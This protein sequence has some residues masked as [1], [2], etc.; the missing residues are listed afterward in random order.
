MVV[1]AASP[2]GELCAGLSRLAPEQALIPTVT[3]AASPRVRMVVEKRENG[4]EGN[5]YQ[6]S[7]GSWFFDF[8]ENL[9]EDEHHGT[10]AGDVAA[11]PKALGGGA[12]PRAFLD[13][14]HRRVG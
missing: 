7:S 11:K 8:A 9:G 6:N 5:S 14:A 3:A 13:S 2:G 4:D 12:T 1:D 10:G